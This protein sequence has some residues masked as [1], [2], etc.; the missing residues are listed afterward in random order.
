MTS[1]TT[2]SS[3]LHQNQEI[4]SSPSFGMDFPNL[5][6]TLNFNVPIK[7]DKNN[8]I[9]WKT[10]ILPAIHALDLEGFISGSKTLLSKTI[11][12]QVTNEGG[13]VI[14]KQQENKEYISWKKSDQMLLF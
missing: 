12:V 10:Q 4:S 11:D 3:N 1:S 14:T 13:Q 7:L 2:D 5:A 9:Y 8:F 6:K